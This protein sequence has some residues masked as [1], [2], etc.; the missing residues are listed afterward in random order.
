MVCRAR[1]LHGAGGSESGSEDSDPFTATPLRIC[2]GME[3]YTAAVVHAACRDPP[4]LSCHPATG[5]QPPTTR[6]LCAQLYHRVLRHRRHHRHYCTIGGT[7]PI[8]TIQRAEAGILS[9]HGH[10]ASTSHCSRLPACLPVRRG[11]PRTCF[12]R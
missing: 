1:Y 2:K 10:T 8:N 6:S 7:L 9:P 4:H 11:R 5:H 3:L 12:M